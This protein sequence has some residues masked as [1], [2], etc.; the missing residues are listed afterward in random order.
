MKKK[1]C[2]ILA[3]SMVLAFLVPVAMAQPQSIPDGPWIQPEQTVKLERLSQPE[4]VE[5]IL[6]DIERRSKGRMKVE[7]IGYSAHYDWPLYVAK[8]GDAD[9]ENKAKILID[10]Q[11]HGGE[12]LGTES[13]LDLISTLATSGNKDVIKILDNVTV[14]FIPMLNMD[15]ATIFEIEGYGQ[16]QSRQ[17]IQHW[18]PEEWGLDVETPAPWYW[19]SMTVRDWDIEGKY[20]GIGGYDMNRDAHPYLDFD[21]NV[22]SDQHMPSGWGGEPGFF[23]CPE[24]RALRDVFKELEPDLYVNHHHRGTN[25]VSEDDIRMCTLQI[26]AQFVPLDRVDTIEDNGIVHTRS[27]SEESLE[28]SKQVN[29]LVY[30]KLQLG[31][32]NPFSAITKYPRVEDYY[33]GEGL[34]GT[35]LASFSMNDAAVMLYEVRSAG[36]KSSGMLVQQ[37]LIGLYETLLGFATGEVYEIDPAFYDD[38]IREAGPRISNPVGGEGGI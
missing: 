9:D 16:A 35:T 33:G 11:I 1:V 34:P 18:T 36:Q 26:Y 8:F 29:A 23:V 17:N 25:L 15:G 28:L 6:F 7:L 5:R 20:A 2:L 27:L 31:G 30:Q 22:H 13:A 10:T 3:I 38:E 37:S 32:N 4:D 21:L 24:I 12:P 19:R 14:W